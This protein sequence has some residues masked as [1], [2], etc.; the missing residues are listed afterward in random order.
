MVKNK[1]LKRKAEKAL[2]Y[3]QK[4]R[5]CQWAYDLQLERQTPET[6][7]NLYSSI[8]ELKIFIDNIT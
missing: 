2:E 4:I 1:A 6:K 7:Q 5:F 3:L 8:D